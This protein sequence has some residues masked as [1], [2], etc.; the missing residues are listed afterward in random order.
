MRVI[1]I[2]AS[3]DPLFPGNGAYPSKEAASQPQLP[4]ELVEALAHGGWQA[5]PWRSGC[6]RLLIYHCEESLGLLRLGCWWDLNHSAPL[7]RP[8]QFQSR[9]HPHTPCLGQC[10][11]DLP[12]NT[13]TGRWNL[14]QRGAAHCDRQQRPSTRSLQLRPKPCCSPGGAAAFLSGRSGLHCRRRELA[15]HHRLALVWPSRSAADWSTEYSRLVLAVKGWAAWMSDGAHASYGSR[16][17]RA[18]L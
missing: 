5:R 3:G 11:W 8:G 2:A 12:I 6:W 4:G 17:N 14:D 18:D 9:T 15:R 16:L 1:Q 7:E 13:S 10:R